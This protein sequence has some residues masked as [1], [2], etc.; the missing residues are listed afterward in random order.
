[1]PPA[2]LMSST[3]TSAFTEF[4]PTDAAQ[5]TRELHHVGREQP[6]GW[7]TFNGYIGDTFVYKMALSDAD[8]A[9]LEADINDQ[10]APTS[11]PTTSRRPPDANGTISP[12]GVTAVGERQ[13]DLHHH[14]ELRL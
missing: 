13:P 9:A 10:D 3:A 4:D 5:T 2:L 6:D 1:M 14:P 12:L 11:P 8:R 7:S